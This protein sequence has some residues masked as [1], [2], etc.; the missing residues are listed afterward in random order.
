[1]GKV[2]GIKLLE[3]S[4]LNEGVYDKVL[5]TETGVKYLGLKNPIGE[6]I[7]AGGEYE[8]IG[9]VE[10]FHAQSFRRDIAPMLSEHMILKNS[11]D[12]I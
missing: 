7:S 12:I 9:I 3:G 10:D 11:I 4:N 1:M 6:I 5:L 8:I 2:L